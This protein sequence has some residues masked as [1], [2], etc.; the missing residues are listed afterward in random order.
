MDGITIG[1]EGMEKWDEFISM[2]DGL[3]KVN[4]SEVFTPEGVVEVKTYAIEADDEDNVKGTMID[5][6]NDKVGQSDIWIRSMPE[7]SEVL[8]YA[9][10]K[11]GKIMGHMRFAYREKPYTY[12]G[13]NDMTITA[14]T[15]SIKELQR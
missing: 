1:G 2:M 12:L 8:T 15:I 3:P 5:L 4:T 14:G 9:G 13:S 11:T 10:E 7:I 6:F